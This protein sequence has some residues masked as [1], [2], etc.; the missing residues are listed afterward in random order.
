MLMYQ[1][2]LNLMKKIDM[3]KWLSS[4]FKGT[5]PL[6]TIFNG[7]DKLSTSDAEKEELRLKAMKLTLDKEEMKFSDKSDARSMYKVDSGLQKLFAIIF[8]V[9]Y[10]AIIGIFFWKMFGG[11]VL[12]QWA[13]NFVFAIFG[14]MS[15]KVNTIVDFLF[16]GSTPNNVP[17]LVNNPLE[18]KK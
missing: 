13:S 14:G 11:L 6:E 18:K 5:N 15:A 10:M 12:E 17:G 9:S 7:I 16:G 3:L 8:L 1:R 2:W 4:L